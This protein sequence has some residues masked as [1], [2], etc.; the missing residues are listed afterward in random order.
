ELREG[1]ITSGSFSPTL[2]CSIALARVPRDIGDEAQV[3]IR[4][5]RV[6]VKVT[7]PGF[8][9]NGQKRV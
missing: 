5:K 8:V 1:V 2:G 6:T 7:Q 4:N 3:A 9:R